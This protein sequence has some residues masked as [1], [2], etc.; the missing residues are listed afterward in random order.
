MSTSDQ[1]TA[2]QARTK[3][4]FRF[5]IIV[6][7]VAVLLVGVVWLLPETLTVRGLAMTATATALVPVALLTLVVWFLGF[8]RFA[9]RTRAIGALAIVI[10]LVGAAGSVRLVEFSGEMVPTFVFRWS[11][12]RPDVLEAHR[13][14]V[15][16][17]DGLAAVTALEIGP[18]DIAE[19]RGAARDGIVEGPPLS[20]QWSSQPLEP[21]W[22]QPVGGGYAA[23]VVVGQTA[24]TIE[25]RREREAIV[26]YDAETGRERWVHD[27]PAL[28]HDTAGG[29]GP[30]ATPTVYDGKVYSMGGTGEL[31]CLDGTNGEL[32]WKLDVL[33]EN[34]T[35]NITWGMSGSPL[36]YDELCVVNPG[37]QE[38]SPDSRAV[39]A[40]DAQTGEVRWKAGR[41][42]A[43]Y[44]SPMLAT[45]AGKRQVLMFDAAGVAGYDA[46][47]GDL[48]WSFPW[49]TLYDINAAQPVV[50]SGDRVF[51]S[52]EA[53]GAMVQITHTED[54]TASQSVTDD[55]SS[56]AP[57]KTAAAAETWSARELWHNYRM[58][59]SYANPVAR[60]GYIYGLDRGILACVDAE[61]G[62][63]A[64]KRGRY[65]HGQLLLADDLLVILSEKGKL[66][67]V[68]ATPEEYRELVRMPA[69]DGKTWN[70]PTLV[71][72]RIYVRN[73]IE[74]ACYDLR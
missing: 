61:T 60:D 21:I 6:V 56:P 10:V 23:F 50:L 5:P 12:L 36:L 24:I 3:S 41:T 58:K 8:G 16:R 67:L 63:R 34:G 48:L 73:H 37:A 66:A 49:T 9:W 2:Q 59:C 44:A 25:Q 71:D 51:I 20:R 11:R 17:A 57:S 33:E 69:I 40:L 46:R 29:D 22:R 54:Q 28:F 42:V 26:A 72:G 30:H 35:T 65:G 43:S 4:R 19:Y 13:E 53:G 52:S 64:W 38:D 15:G 39:W 68:E 1:T 27:Y 70:N 31:V 32:L 47:L 18:L 55:P 7:I 14:S 74:M 45:L 62:K